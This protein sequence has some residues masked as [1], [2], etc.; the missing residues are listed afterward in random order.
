MLHLDGFEQYAN[1]SNLARPLERA[2]YTVVGNWAS[3]AGRGRYSRAISGVKTSIVRTVD[4][5][6]PALSIGFAGS[7][8]E[9]GAMAWLKFGEA[10]VV[11]WFDHDTGLPNLNTTVGGA[12]P[13]TNR[14]Y[15]YEI[16]CDRDSGSCSLYINGRFDCVFNVPGGLTGD[17][18]EVGLGYRDPADYRPGVD[19]APVDNSAKTF[20][21]FYIRPDSKYS[22]IM[23]TTRFPD[24]DVTT[25]WFKAGTKITHALTVSTL[26]TDPLNTYIASDTIGKEDA[27]TSS[28][29]L[30]NENPII[31]TGLLVL[32]RKSP[33]LDAQ[34]G[35]SMGGSISERGADL[36]VDTNWR[37][38]FACFEAQDGDDPT[39]IAASQFGVTVSPS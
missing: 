28:Q 25:D 16:E 20:D 2:D 29:D 6:E 33:T 30:N 21:D 32:A 10:E 5:T 38:Q 37:T 15:F 3:V 17:T 24:V 36:V 9:R 34:L 18:V 4:W 26:P 35:V 7:F 22:P 1:E 19:P 14:Y 12:L 13:T 39:T 8:T 11:L 27:F 31:A 23:I